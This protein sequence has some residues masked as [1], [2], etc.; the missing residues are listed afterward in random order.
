MRDKTDIFKKNIQI[1]PPPKM[2]QND[3]CNLYLFAMEIGAGS[4][5]WGHFGERSEKIWCKL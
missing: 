2:S 4:Y 3:T 1:D 5:C